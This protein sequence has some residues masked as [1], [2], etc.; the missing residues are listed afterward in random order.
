MEKAEWDALQTTLA[1]VKKTMDQRFEKDA[2]LYIDQPNIEWLKRKLHEKNYD[3]VKDRMASGLA[4]EA[5]TRV[6]VENAWLLPNNTDHDAY[7]Q[8]FAVMKR[9]RSGYLARGDLAT[10]VLSDSYDMPDAFRTELAEL[11]LSQIEPHR[12][13]AMLNNG[14]GL[15]PFL[16]NLKLWIACLKT[17]ISQ[18]EPMDKYRQFTAYTENKPGTY[19]ETHWKALNRIFDKTSLTDDVLDAAFNDHFMKEHSPGYYY[20]RFVFGTRCEPKALPERAGRVFLKVNMNDGR[21]LWSCIAP[22]ITRKE[23]MDALA[24]V[25]RKIAPQWHA[26]RLDSLAEIIVSNLSKRNPDFASKAA[27]AFSSGGVQIGVRQENDLPELPEISRMLDDDRISDGKLYFLAKSFKQ[28]YSR[29]SPTDRLNELK[30][31]TQSQGDCASGNFEKFCYKLTGNIPYQY[32]VPYLIYVI[33]NF[34][35]QTATNLVLQIV[36]QKDIFHARYV[37]ASKGALD[38]LKSFVQEKDFELYKKLMS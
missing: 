21:R 27:Q 9:C 1:R 29:N 7:W 17:A 2:E 4:P 10:G 24:D 23:T 36:Q 6:I 8:L 20:W 28:R 19:A 5:L 38:R 15:L 22:A 31:M 30:E 34:Q 11:C 25:F 33:E 26:N 13:Q 32:V 14:A 12:A 3:A 35:N 37:K 18:L 16:N